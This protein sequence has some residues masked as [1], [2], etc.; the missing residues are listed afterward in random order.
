MGYQMQPPWVKL[1]IAV[2]DNPSKAGEGGRFL[3]L[4]VSEASV[5]GPVAL[6]F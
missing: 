5:C 2:T 1:P 4:R 3:G 6:P